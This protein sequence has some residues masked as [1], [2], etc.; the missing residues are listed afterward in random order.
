MRK[1]SCCV[2]TCCLHANLFYCTCSVYG[3]YCLPK[4]FGPYLRSMLLAFII[5]AIITFIWLGSVIYTSVTGGEAVKAL[6]S[7]DMPCLIVTRTG[8]VTPCPP[9]P[10]PAPRRP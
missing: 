1:V 4:V 3:L 10:P 9:A 6:R 8:N 5:A 7:L 2:F